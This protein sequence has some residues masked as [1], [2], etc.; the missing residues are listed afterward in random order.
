MKKIV[1]FCTLLLFLLIIVTVNTIFQIDK[2]ERKLKTLLKTSLQ[3]PK[4]KIALVTL[5][6]R[7][8]NMLNMHNKNIKK[9]ADK[10]GYTYIY[11]NDYKNDL[12]LPIYWKKLQLLKE[13]MENTNYDYIVWLDSDTII[14]E[15]DIRLESI[16]D[17]TR[18]GIFIGYDKY[19]NL[20]LNAGVFILRNDNKTLRFI[21]QCINT[22]L[23]R[24]KCKNEQGEYV[25]NGEWSKDCY[26][27]GIMNELLFKDYKKELKVLKPYVVTNDSKPEKRCFILHLFNGPNKYRTDYREKIFKN[28]IQHN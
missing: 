2:K 5:E 27:Q 18:K 9:Y 1:C 3:S 20:N 13:L 15:D 22:Y 14:I 12:K 4:Y 23:N 7:P 11:L 19:N 21:E 8:S 16:I 10:H 17:K 25:L 26:E 28:I 24:E 6:T